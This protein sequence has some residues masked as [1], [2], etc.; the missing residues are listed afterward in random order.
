MLAKNL[1][2]ILKGVPDNAEILIRDGVGDEF[3]TIAAF[4]TEN[5]LTIRVDDIIF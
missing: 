2:Q 3:N 1:K 4:Y 5:T